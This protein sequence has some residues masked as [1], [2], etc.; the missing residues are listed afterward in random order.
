MASVAVSNAAAGNRHPF[1][2]YDCLGNVTQ[3]EPQINAQTPRFT[4]TY[5][6]REQQSDECAHATRVTSL[7][8]AR[9]RDCVPLVGKIAA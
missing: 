8:A 7:R 1:S 4:T 2:S 5:E 3:R 9:E 6:Q